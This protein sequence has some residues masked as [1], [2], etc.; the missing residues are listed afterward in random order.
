MAAGRGIMAEAEAKRRLVAF[1]EEKAFRPV[2]DAD[3]DRFPEAKRDRLRDMQRRTQTEIERFRHYGS[4]AEVV[5]NFKRDLT[6][7]PAKKVHRALKE[8]GL[9]T[10]DD[11]REEFEHLADEVG[12]D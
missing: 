11:V 4:A 9:P 3:P 6:S 8:L 7:E 1:L 12:H 10:I 2:L 5:T